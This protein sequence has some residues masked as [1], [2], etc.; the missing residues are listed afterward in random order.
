MSCIICQSEQ[1]EWQTLW[2]VDTGPPQPTPPPQ[3][4]SRYIP[5]VKRAGFPDLVTTRK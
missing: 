4:V 1:N 5:R 2:R 3:G